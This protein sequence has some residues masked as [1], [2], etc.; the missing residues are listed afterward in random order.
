M[1]PRVS[2]FASARHVVQRERAAVGLD[3]LQVGLGFAQVHCGHLRDGQDHG[4]HGAQVERGFAAGHVDRSSRTGSRR[5][6]DELRLIRA[7]AGGEDIRA[8][9]SHARIDHKAVVG[10]LQF[11]ASKQT[12]NFDDD[13]D[14][15]AAKP[16]VR[17]TVPS[18]VANTD[19]SATH[20]LYVFSSFP[21]NQGNPHH[22]FSL[23]PL[24]MKCRRLS[25]IH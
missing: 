16:D 22:H 13:Q 6:V 7:I 1:K 20:L 17:R 15:N 8:R 3:A 21:I 12:F 18:S 10:K 2:K 23:V 9:R 5:H 14:R 4:R 25:N 11:V 24:K 19:C